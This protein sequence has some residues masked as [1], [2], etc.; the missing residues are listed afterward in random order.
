MHEYGVSL[1]SW[2]KLPRAQAI[3]LAVAHREFRA[4]RID[5]YVAKLETGGLFVDV[6]CQAD[7]AGLRSRG[8]SVWRL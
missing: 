5:E 8:V 4:R 2:D 1:A 6:K 3:V 7:A